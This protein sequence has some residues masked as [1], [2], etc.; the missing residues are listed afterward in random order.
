MSTLLPT[1][2]KGI[3]Y[4]T[5]ENYRSTAKDQDMLYFITDKGGAIYRGSE[6]VIPAKPIE[7]VDDWYNLATAFSGT[8]AYAVGD[9]VTYTKSGSAGFYKCHTAEAASQTQRP[10]PDD[11]HFTYF[12]AA[13]AGRI[14]RIVISCFNTHTPVQGETGTYP[15]TP[16]Q[17]IVDVYTPEAMNAIATAWQAAL[18]AH[19]ETYATDT[20]YGHVRLWDSADATKDA[21]GHWAATPKAVADAISAA[22]GGIG[23]AMVFKGTI[24]AASASPTVTALPAN[25]YEAG[26]T[27][28]VVTAGTYAGKTCEVGDLIISVANGPASGSS[29][30]NAHWTVA[31]TNIDGAVTA[32]ANLDNNT[33]VL[34]AGNKTVKKLPNGQVGDYLRINNNGTPEWSRHNIA[35]MRTTGPDNNGVFSADY[36]TTQ[37]T[38]E[39]TGAIFD[40]LTPGTLVAVHFNKNFSGRDNTLVVHNRKEPTD[41]PRPILHNGDNLV[42]S[43]VIQEGS[44]ALLMFEGAHNITI[45]GTTYDQGVWRLLSVDARKAGMS[46]FV[47]DMITYAVCT[48]A[49]GTAAKTASTTGNGFTLTEGALVAV[50]FSNANNA[51]GPTLSVDST[52]AVAIS[53]DSTKWEA[54]DVCLFMYDK[55]DTGSNAAYRW[56]MVARHRAIDGTVTQGSTNLITSGA[57]QTAIGN[58]Q[59]TLTNTTIP[60]AIGAA[61]ASHTFVG[62]DTLGASIAQRQA[63]GNTVSLTFGT[64]AVVRFQN[65]VNV[66]NASLALSG[67]NGV[68]YSTAKYIYK[69]GSPLAPG[70]ILTGDTCTFVYD[71]TYW[72][73]VAFSREGLLWSAI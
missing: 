47:N 11:G 23:G 25:G 49:A 10:G 1:L 24:G 51:N 38:Y 46:Q 67:D 57:V 70:V 34:G 59:S 43:G 52:T 45:A 54:N 69:D 6:L 71:G 2:V 60:N 13:Q 31:Q 48:T 28:R 30:N 26:W 42:E 40:A 14:K 29:V 64:V 15:D 20:Q 33:L 19:A 58:L 16:T 37:N 35:Y 55:D 36:D 50:K 65:G 5:F 7:Q 8:A 56:L 68:T 12:G 41:R 17:F 62:V 39:D 44:T 63:L 21:A 27:Y 4:G 73:L 3:K 72:Q 53:S 22:I 32:A 66:S 9:I 18:A 61:L